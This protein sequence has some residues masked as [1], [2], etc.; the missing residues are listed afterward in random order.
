[1]FGQHILF[2][3]QPGTDRGS[4]PQRSTVDRLAL[5]AVVS[6]VRA[7]GARLDGIFGVVPWT[8]AA[9]GSSVSAGECVVEVPVVAAVEP[10]DDAQWRCCL[11]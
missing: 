11:E 10:V 3:V 2:C 1:M 7:F 4:S 6:D 9:W 8:V 5:V